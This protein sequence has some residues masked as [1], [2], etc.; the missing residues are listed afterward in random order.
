MTCGRTG[1]ARTGQRSAV[2]G[3]NPP[4]VVGV[5]VREISRSAVGYP[6]IWVRP[7]HRPGRSSARSGCRRRTRGCRVPTG[8]RATAATSAVRLIRPSAAY[9][10]G[11]ADYRRS[12]RRGTTAEV[13]AGALARPLRRACLAEVLDPVV[14]GVASSLGTWSELV[15]GTARLAAEPAALLAVR[16]L[17]TSLLTATLPGVQHGP[18]GERPAR[19]IGAEHGSV[20]EPWVGFSGETPTARACWPGVVVVGVGPP[21]TLL[22][23]RPSRCHYDLLLPRLKRRLC[24]MWS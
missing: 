17:P 12:R 21:R 19:M 3:S 20:G 14:V 10:R 1:S 9:R 4:R 24:P 16:L 7:S 23:L 11:C 13:I 6:G 8:Q 2:C 22:V 15:P 18:N 5:S